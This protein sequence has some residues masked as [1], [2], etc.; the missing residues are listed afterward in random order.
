MHIHIYIYTYIYIYIS[1]AILAQAILAQVLSQKL[2][3]LPL[4][5]GASFRRS[6]NNLKTQARKSNTQ[7]E[8]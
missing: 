6:D 5:P 4:L 1:V 7:A 2:V 8:C 3:L